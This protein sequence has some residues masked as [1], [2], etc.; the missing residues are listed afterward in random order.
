VACFS[1][2]DAWR[3][4]GG[5]IVFFDRGGGRH[6]TLPCG[7]CVG[8]RLERSRQWAVRIMH[9]ASLHDDN[10]FITLTYDE[11]NVPRDGSLDKRHFQL[12][13]KRMR[14]RLGSFR[15]FHCGEYGESLGRPHY[16]ACV[17]GLDFPDRELYRSS[18]ENRLYTSKI[19]DDLWQ[20]G[21]A[22][23]GDLSFESAAYVARY[24]MKKVTGDAAD[25]HYLR[26]SDDGE[27]IRLLPEYVTMSRRPGIARDWFQK[28]GNEVFPADEV[29]SRGFPAR[30]PRY[31][32]SLLEVSE[33]SVFDAV[34]R[35]RRL[36]VERFS[37]NCT[38]ERLAVREE[39][40]HARVRS[41]KRALL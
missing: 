14:K 31:Y 5:E 41:L 38:T 21:F 13:C 36:D 9:E 20:L 37:D 12:F 24:V 1:P 40:T 26:F 6:L 35:K 10:C 2:L 27:V 11:D 29:I 19:L 16:H 25:E 17:F 23:V 3:T 34:K 33:P 7:Q 8:C 30:P 39:C 22:T 28:F 32:D 4:D 18:G 15:F